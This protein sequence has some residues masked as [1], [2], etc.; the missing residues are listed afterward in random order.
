[1]DV[2]EGCAEEVLRCD[3][4]DGGGEGGL[5]CGQA[6]QVGE[7]AGVVCEGGRGEDLGFCCV[8]LRGGKAWVRFGWVGVELS[9]G[10]KW[11]GSRWSGLG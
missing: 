4:G 2:D 10:V 8:S 11:V 5:D 6:G 9:D 3:V 7:E 1:M